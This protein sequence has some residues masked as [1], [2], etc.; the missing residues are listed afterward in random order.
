MKNDKAYVIIRDDGFLNVRRTA[1]RQ[2]GELREFVRYSIV[3]NLCNAT[4][5]N[6]RKNAAQHTVDKDKIKPVR[7]EA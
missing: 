5:F 6:A 7:V 2:Y 1:K 4:L 3:D